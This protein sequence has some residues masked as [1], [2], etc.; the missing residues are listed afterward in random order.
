MPVGRAPYFIQEHYLVRNPYPRLERDRLDL[1]KDG[2]EYS[3][4]HAKYHPSLRRIARQFGYYDLFLI[5]NETGRIVYTVSKEPDFGTSLV[6]GP[7][8]NTA[9]AKAFQACRDNPDV[10]AACLTDF[11][12]YEPSLGAPAAFMASPINDGDRRV[13]VLALQ[14]SIDEIDRVVSGNHGW[15]KDG[16][17]KTGDSGIVGP[18]FLMRTNSR[19][20]V[21]D[22]EKHLA[23]MRAR[24]VPEKQI[25]RIR[26]YKTTALQQMVKLPSVV[27]A[28]KGEEGLRTQPGSSGARSLIAYGPLR[29]PGL[30]WTIAS[31]MDEAEALAAVVEMRNKMLIWGLAVLL[32]TAFV[33]LMASRAIVRP[34]QVLAGASKKVAAGDL[35]VEVPVTSKDEIG[36]LSA[37]FNSM[38]KDLRASAELTS[39]QAEATKLRARLDAMHSEIGAALV[40]SQ[41]FNDMMKRCAEALH[42]RCGRSFRAYLDA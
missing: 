11:E 4:V 21:D 32:I 16:L 7:Y 36:S 27:A 1:A 28:L 40:Q 6:K 24:G 17:G 29:V 8:R 37:T 33:A 15:E 41:D 9:L 5:D 13:G 23:R 35:T 14:L 25:A 19:G 12:D 3:R 10:D 39:A 26:A 31:R 18:D 38:V 34:L 2:S 42:G 30:H 22:P 20:Y